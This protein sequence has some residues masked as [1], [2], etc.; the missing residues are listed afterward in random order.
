MIQR[1]CLLP[2]EK[3]G[4]AIFLRAARGDA[5]GDQAAFAL[6]QAGNV[7]GL[8]FDI[9]RRNIHFHMQSLGDPDAMGLERIFLIAKVAVQGLHT[10]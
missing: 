4:E 5:S 3:C 6:R 2:Y 7:A 1:I 8:S 9:G 10:R